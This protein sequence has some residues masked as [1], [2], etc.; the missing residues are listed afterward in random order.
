MYV[1]NILR[2]FCLYLF[3]SLLFL[4]F[5]EVPFFYSVSLFFVLL[6]IDFYVINLLHFLLFLY[7]IFLEVPFFYYFIHFTIFYFTFGRFLCYQSAT[8][9]LISAFILPRVYVFLSL[10]L[11]HQSL[12]CLF[13]FGKFVCHQSLTFLILI[14]FHLI[15][16][17]SLPRNPVSI[18]LSTSPFFILLLIDFCV[19]NLLNFFLFL[20]LFFL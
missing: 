8:F 6:L 9:P 7:L 5:L 17:P 13:I 4:F 11:L 1:I 19:I 18:T 10:S 20:H 3:I 12:E 15:S 14:S 2:F 16:V